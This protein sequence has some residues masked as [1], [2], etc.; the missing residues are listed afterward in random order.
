MEIYEKGYTIIQRL[1]VDKKWLKVKI[2]WKWLKEDEIVRKW[3]K[4]DESGW[5]Q[6]KVDAL[7]ANGWGWTKVNKSGQMF[8]NRT[9]EDESRW[10][11]WKW[12]KLDQAWKLEKVKHFDRRDSSWRLACGDVCII[13]WFKHHDQIF[14]TK[15]MVNI[16]RFGV[17]SIY[18]LH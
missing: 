16:A 4:V 9:K 3:M 2:G 15:G 6:M 11:W 7:D 13:V 5:K 1:K 17:F 14:L 12:V 18:L 10:E 8:F